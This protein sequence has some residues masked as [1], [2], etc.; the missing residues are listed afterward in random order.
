MRQVLASQTSHSQSFVPAKRLAAAFERNILNARIHFIYFVTIQKPG[1]IEKGWGRYHDAESSL[2][3]LTT[4]VNQQEEL[5]PLRIPVAKLRADLNAYDPAL[6]A[7]LQMVQMGEFKGAHYD[8]Q[9]KEW[10]ARGAVM[11]TDAGNVETLA[12]A[13]SEASTDRMVTSVKLA[14][15]R[16][17]LIFA[18]GLLLCVVSTTALVGKLN[19]GQHSGSGELPAG[20]DQPN[21]LAEGLP[22]A[23]I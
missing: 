7:T 5:K 18:V 2:A 11:V 21:G 23:R 20:S 17:L 8:A 12:S 19:Q 10:A 9:V 4:L 14:E 1:T 6:H 13:T 22:V 3:E 16:V 15:V